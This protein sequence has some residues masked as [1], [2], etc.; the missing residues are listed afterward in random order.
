MLFI[1]EQ[2]HVTRPPTHPTAGRTAMV[3]I[4]YSILSS[5][6]FL[7]LLCL[8]SFQSHVKLLKRYVRTIVYLVKTYLVTMFNFQGLNCLSRRAPVTLGPEAGTTHGGRAT[9]V[10]VARREGETVLCRTS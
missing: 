9:A 5:R 4:Y 6:N 8:V 2:M 7:P 10:T 1:V 3:F